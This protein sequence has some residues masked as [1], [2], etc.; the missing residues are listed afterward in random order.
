L[1]SARLQRVEVDAR[2]S[3][4]TD[5]EQAHPYKLSHANWRSPQ[6][7]PLFVPVHKHTELKRPLIGYCE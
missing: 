7:L 5:D 6:L 1:E 2:R 3:P 4:F